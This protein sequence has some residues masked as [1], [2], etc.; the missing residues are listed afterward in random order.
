MKTGFSAWYVIE[1]DNGYVGLDQG[2]GGYPFLTC[3]PNEIRFWNSKEA[4]EDYIRMF[5][6]SFVSPKVTQRE[7]SKYNKLYNNER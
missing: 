2:S 3:N 4:A 6:N 7:F 1:T 5:I